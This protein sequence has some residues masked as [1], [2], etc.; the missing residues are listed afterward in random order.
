MA[1]DVQDA[2]E[3]DARRV[4]FVVSEKMDATAMQTF[5]A[6]VKAFIGENN[7]T[8]AQ[9]AKWINN[10]H[11]VVS[12][13]LSG[14]YEGNL[15][16]IAGKIAGVL[17]TL[18]RKKRQA[19]REKHVP[20]GT[21]KRIGTLIAE[22]QAFGDSEGRIGLVIGDSGHGK[23]CCLRAYA[24]ADRNSV[25]VQYDDC[26]SGKELFAELA[27]AARVK[28]TGSLAAVTERLILAVK[29][30]H[31]LVMIDEASSMGPRLLNRLRQVL[32]AKAGCS[33]ILGAN[34]ELLHTVRNTSRGA[35]AESLD[36]FNSRLM[37][38]L[39]LDELAADPDDPL[40]TADDVRRLYEYGGIKLSRD[41]TDALRRLLSMPKSGRLRTAGVII[42]ALHMSSRIAERG[43]IDA[44]A[45]L[46]AAVELA[47][48][49]ADWLPTVCREARREM[50][51]AAV[52]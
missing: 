4:E 10:H 46:A 21:A 35:G 39:T 24:A 29:D 3:Q 49:I 12:Q 52:G 50:Q 45:I 44:A 25:Y 38:I 32:V 5:V 1:K 20:T 2:L 16:N 41:A 8:Q 43:V 47:L 17:N 15:V 14:K 51:T 7:I 19:P 34:A 11:V 27:R 28:S 18:A 9:L 13:F 48:P 36:Q 30:R 37:S 22:V 6:D 26:M 33:L 40:Y 31:L 42:A 23:S